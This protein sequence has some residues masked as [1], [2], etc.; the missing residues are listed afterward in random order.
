MGTDYAELAELGQ[1]TIRTTAMPAD[2]N[3]NGDIFGGW[4]MGQMDIAGGSTAIQRAQGRV[5]TVAVDAMTFHKPVF[6]GDEVS[7]YTRIERVGNTSI[8]IRV[9]TWVRRARTRELIKVTEGTFVYV[10]IDGN[11]RPRPIPAADEVNAK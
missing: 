11:G 2:T 4:L 8:S 3:P 7:C 10:A 9:E 5:A 6:V 1:L